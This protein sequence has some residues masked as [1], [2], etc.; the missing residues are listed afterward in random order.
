M[1]RYAITGSPVEVVGRISP[2]PLL[3]VHGDSDHYFP[4]EHPEALYAA[5]REPKELW[6]LE[7]FGHAE[8]AADLAEGIGRLDLA[9]AA[10]LWYSGGGAFQEQTFGYTGRPSSGQKSFM[11]VFD[12]SG[13]YQF[14]PQ[15]TFTL[16]VAHASG[17]AVVQ[18]IFP[19]GPKANFA[20]VELNRR[21]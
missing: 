2:I 1:L 12:F 19:G 4:V 6:L 16:Y 8:S 5:A 18:H 15:T 17:R 14:D 3:I 21:F 11:A 20:Y 10:D 9:S 13:D 7:G